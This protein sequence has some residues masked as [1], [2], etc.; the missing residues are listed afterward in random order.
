M[1][2]FDSSGTNEKTSIFEAITQ[3]EIPY[4]ILA[5]V[6]L[7]STNFFLSIRWRVL[8]NVVN[9]KVDLIE[10]VKLSFLGNFV[11][12]FLPGTLGGDATKM[13]FVAKKTNRKLDVVFSTLVDRIFGI[14]CYAFQALIMTIIL[15][16]FSDMNK[17]DLY[18]PALSIAILATFGFVGALILLTPRIRSFLRFENL[19]Q[20]YN[21][22]PN[23]TS[24]STIGITIANN[25]GVLTKVIFYTLLAQG[26]AI[27]SVATLG[28]SLGLNVPLSQYF[29]FIPLIILL[30]AF[31]ITPGG[32]GVME[33]LYLLYFA[34]T[35][36]PAKV[37]LLALLARVT[38]LLSSLP[39]S[40]VILFGTKSVKQQLK[41]I[42]TQ[43]VQ[44]KAF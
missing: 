9:V 23:V 40:L 30:S 15:Y 18:G 4:L 34:S 38:M 20:K 5:L 11:S 24:F 27:I 10:L 19:F 29:L 35:G 14:G 31:P 32:I 33:E 12:M 39:G 26:I 25:L 21:P 3:I 42:K 44:K 28:V 36:D 6:L 8:L 13:Y 16:F 41:E 37:L 17:E 7:I 2:W 22:F 1:I 43:A